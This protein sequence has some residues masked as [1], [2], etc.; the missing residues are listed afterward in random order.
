MSRARD[1][2]KAVAAVVMLAASATWARGADPI[3]WLR[4]VDGKTWESTRPD[5]LA[6]ALARVDGGAN[7][8]EA[9]DAEEYYAR[10]LVRTV[11]GEH[12]KAIA[13]FDKAI[14]LDPKYVDAYIAR[15]IC[16]AVK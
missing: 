12:D 7:R 8:D 15:G 11:V 3:D 6:V 13:D 9:E 16:W 4:A 1:V 14:R 10:G 2:C 5:D